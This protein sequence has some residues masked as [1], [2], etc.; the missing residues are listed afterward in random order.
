M[1]DTN[2][3]PDLIVVG[4]GLAG[5]CAA[6]TA[7]EKGYRVT[8]LEKLDT[9]GGSS[10]LSG[11]CLAF[12]GTDLQ[13]NQGIKD[14]SD[15]L[16]ADLVEVGKHES[17][18][19]LVRTY[20][21]NQH[22]TYEWLKKSGVSFGE[23]LE[24]ASG[25][26]APRSH[27]V[28]PADMI[29]VLTAR[30]KE[31]DN[32]TLLPKSSASRLL[33]DDNGRVIGIDFVQDGEPKQLHSK[34]GVILT[35][36]GF[37]KN[38][39]MVHKFAPQYDDAVFIGGEGNIGDGL[40]MAC[41]LGADLVDM[42]HIKGTF[43]KHPTDETNHHS[44][45]AVYKGAIAVNQDGK[46]FVNES[47]SYK[48]LGDACIRQPYGAAFQI[49]DQNILK[50]GDNQFRIFDFERR[51]EA[52]LMYEEP[53]LEKLA[54]TIDIPV[55]TL[56]D[57]VAQYNRYVEEGHDPDFGRTSLVQGHGHLVKIETGPFYAYPSTVAVFGT[58]C[59]IKVNKRMQVI[60]VFGEPIAGLYAA[61]EIVG[62]LHGAAYMTGSAL[63]KAAIFGRVA[64]A[65]ATES[66]TA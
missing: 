7:A 48:L 57:T 63:G 38:K 60:D 33:T 32:L 8:L 25:Q 43:G 50:S 29:R 36:G 26:S 10:A 58:Y 39:A 14:S 20:V 55:K 52:G 35:S 13:A 4:A 51:L 23:R 46:R 44:C 61:G 21:D 24:A 47:I 62:G 37:S 42:V 5:L 31:F 45:L 56:L 6:L 28:D 22:T 65:A 27:N 3:D 30:K 12:A 53:S 59:G 49:L 64:A 66:V 2:L 34:Y 19:S 15:Q 40:R 11:G 54:E 16:Y 9:T 1:A 17:D 18:E 41:K